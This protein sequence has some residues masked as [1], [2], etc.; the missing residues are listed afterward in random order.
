MTTVS[1]RSKTS[2][3]ASEMDAYI[4]RRLQFSQNTLEI[5][6]QADLTIDHMQYLIPF[7]YFARLTLGEQYSWR[8]I[9]SIE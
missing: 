4:A 6:L 3:N 7:T 2:R 5:C 9:V 8:A 1:Q